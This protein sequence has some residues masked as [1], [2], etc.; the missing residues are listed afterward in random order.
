MGRL[1]LMMFQAVL[2][3]NVRAGQWLVVVG[4]GGGLGHLAGEYRR[5]FPSRNRIPQKE[6]HQPIP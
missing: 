3:A 2:N 1:R 6:I 4:A 5:A